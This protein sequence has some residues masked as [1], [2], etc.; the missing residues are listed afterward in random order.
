MEYS[1]LLVS[2]NY[3]P[4][5]TYILFDTLYQCAK[6][7][8][9]KYNVTYM[10]ETKKY[11]YTYHNDKM[12]IHN[13]IY[14]HNM[15]YDSIPMYSQKFFS[16]AE[17]ILKITRPSKFKISFLYKNNEMVGFTLSQ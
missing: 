8:A 3:E 11:L 4:A 6:K 13:G 7:Y 14:I 15:L 1:G 12:I 10:N 16:V 5:L 9:Y 2:F 17:A